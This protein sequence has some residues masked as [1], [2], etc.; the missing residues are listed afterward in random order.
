MSQDRRHK[1]HLETAHPSSD[2]GAIDGVEASPSTGVLAASPDVDAAGS[3]AACEEYIESPSAT[4]PGDHRSPEE[5]VSNYA[6]YI[7]RYRA[8]EPHLGSDA[9]DGLETL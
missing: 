6:E 2:C 8:V 5:Q 9:I 7:A 4:E 1:G 3:Q